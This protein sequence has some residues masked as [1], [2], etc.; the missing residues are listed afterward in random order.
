MFR[1]FR[2]AYWRGNRLWRMLGLV[3]L[4]WLARLWAHREDFQHV[5]SE[6]IRN[7]IVVNLCYRLDLYHR[8]LVGRPFEDHIDVVR[9]RGQVADNHG[10]LGLFVHD[11]AIHIDLE[12][13]IMSGHKHY[14]VLHGNM[15][16]LLWRNARRVRSVGMRTSATRLCHHKGSHH[17]D[18]E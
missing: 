2:G 12:F 6:V 1:L 17:T 14:R 15:W 3:R 4:I 13:L 7:L 8:D 10:V 16:G 18:K 5:V 9:L 11:V